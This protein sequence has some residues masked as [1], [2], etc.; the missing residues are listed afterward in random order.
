MKRTFKNALLIGF[1]AFATANAQEQQTAAQNIK[2]LPPKTTKPAPNV[3][4]NRM[5][6]EMQEQRSLAMGQPAILK[7]MTY[8]ND[9]LNMKMY[10]LRNGLSVWISVNKAE[11]RI[12]TMIA[13]KA[14]S[15]NDPATH[16]GLAHYLEHM[17]FKGTDK[18]GTKDYAKEKVQLDIIEQLYE[19]YGAEKDETKRAQIYHLIDSVSGVAANYA[20]ANEYD[21]MVSNLGAK[22][23]NAFTSTDMTVYVNDIPANQLS[24]WLTLEAERFHNPVLRL[25]HTE[26]EAVYEEKN[27]ALD[28]DPRKMA[29]A[30]LAS[31][32]KNH[33]YGTQTTIGTIEHLKSPSI[34]EIK[35]YFNA[36]YVPNNMCIILCGDLDPDA[37]IAKINELWG[38]YTPKTVAPYTYQPE[39][40][41]TAPEEI[42]VYGPDK[43]Q[44]IIGYRWPGC[45]SDEYFTQ[46]MV[47]AILSN[48]TAGL[49]NL[50]L[51]M[52]QK[53]LRAEAGLDENTD[54]N[55]YELIAN[56][57][58]GQKLEECR[59]LLLQQIEKLK[60]GE[61]D[62]NMLSAIIA[63]MKVDD[64]KRL[65]SNQGRAYAM[66]NMF[67]HNVNPSA[68]VSRYQIM[69]RLSKQD[70]INFAKTH[71]TNDYTV[72][73][74]RIGE[75]KTTKK[76]VKPAITPVSINRVDQSDFLKN[77]NGMTVTEL[78]PDFIQFDRAIQKD[79][80]S[81]G[82][83][84]WYIKNT[85]NQL[86]NLYYLFD[87]G[88]LSDKALS[89]AMSYLQLL[90]TDKQSAEQVQKAFFQLACE[91]GVN[92]TDDQTYITLSG[93]QEHFEDAVTLLENVL[94]HCAADESALNKMVEGIIK[95]RNDA[96]KNKGAIR[97]RLTA[98]AVYGENSPATFILKNEE[99][100]A[101]K[102]NDL[103]AKI[104]GLEN[105]AHK[106]CYVGPAE[107]ISVKASLQ[108]LHP[109]PAKPLAVPL[110]FKPVRQNTNAQ[111]LF[112]D[113]PMVQA[114]IVWVNKNMDWSEKS[115][116]T[117]R[118]FNE[119][120]GGSMSGV[121]FQTIRESKALAYSCSATYGTPSKK[122]DPFYMNAYVG[123]QADKLNEAIP[124][125][126]E[127]FS[128]MPY[129]EK[130]FTDAKEALKNKI[131][132]ERIRRNNILF[133]YLSAQKLG[134]DK[135]I[136]EDVYH[137]LNVL[138]F[139]AIRAFEEKQIKTVPYTYC[140]LASS[141]KVKMEDLQKYGPVT[142]LTVSQL[143]G[144]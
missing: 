43:E 129:S 87:M 86:F 51:V 77:I 133:T 46:Q 38:N 88:S 99:M 124:A 75:D 111:V 89:P 67:V 82:T 29:E 33:A 71:F 56:P 137:S 143:F 120:F 81:N 69:G 130:A 68:F 4:P 73:Y 44:V 15:K 117:V 14:G 97:S 45:K 72:V 113:Y 10:H 37:T 27:R 2:K 112:V 104:H 94:N 107:M 116:P 12:Q 74:K 96:M 40:V 57:R 115:I 53:V 134:L 135:D 49:I 92:V 25:F 9:D 17:L 58:E 42:S 100:K 121:V 19:Q 110:A 18:Y 144:Y 48:G 108:K 125:M 24:K 118:L 41:R 85:D 91:F 109:M 123:T 90:G 138:D 32:F 65:E 70:I 23:T 1:L 84:Y 35:K 64:M 142:T 63:N 114:E 61:F 22:G 131:E 3:G 141:K 93:A 59:D 132:S 122:E 30:M 139:N 83:P 126:N 34:T 78:K 127:L 140:V 47:D 20:I 79:Q 105:Y 101:L 106:I 31:L 80:M 103:I 7:P 66:E 26:L 39:T 11:P 6:S 54:Y 98:Y 8:Q 13:V 136:R 21:K 128:N 5:Q 76:V 36:N 60:N 102:A 16:T 55:V 50:N 28:N 62:E 52:T 95:D 119:Y